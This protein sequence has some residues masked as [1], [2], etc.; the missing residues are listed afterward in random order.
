MN[1]RKKINQTLKGKAKKANA[2]KTGSN[3]PKYV[4]KA[5]RELVQQTEQQGASQLA[6]SSDNNQEVTAE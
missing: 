3:K 6:V 5:E 1:R 2:K 4:S